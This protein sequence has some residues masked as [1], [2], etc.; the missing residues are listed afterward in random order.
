VVLGSAVSVQIAKSDFLSAI[1]PNERDT[2]AQIASARLKGEAVL[3]RYEVRRLRKDG[4]TIWCEMMAKRIEHA[5][6]PAVMGNII[7]IT[8]RKRAEEEKKVLAANLQ[9]VQKMESIGTLA[10]GIAHDFNNLLM[11]IQGNVSLVLMDLDSTHPYYKRLKTIEKQVQNGAKLTSHLLGYARKGK[12]EV[13]AVDLNQLVEET[14]ETFGRTRK[15]ITI[16]RE[17]ADGLFAIEADSGQIEQVLLNLFVNAADAMPGGGGLILKTMNTTH[18]DMK[19]KVY[20]PKPGKYVMLTVT[21]TGMGMDKETM[22]RVFD[23]FFTTKEMGLGTG[24]GLASAYGI[25]KGHGG[26]IDVESEKGYG[27]TFSTC[28]HQKKRSGRSL[29]LL[30]RSLKGRERPSWL[31]MKMLS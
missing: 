29:K 28:L 18:D 15:Q 7:D 19:G 25:I 30:K 20:D 24:L 12:Y 26:Y 8:E 6:R 2:L 11:G 13:K 21:D 4:T 3:Q 14:S 31:T 23:P 10:G 17:V 22:E 5:G 1:H 9:Q 16:H 27:A